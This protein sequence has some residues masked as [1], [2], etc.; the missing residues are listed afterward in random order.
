MRHTPGPLKK[1]GRLHE[2][3]HLKSTEGH[4]VTVHIPRNKRDQTGQTGTD[5]QFELE[6]NAEHIIACWNACEGIDPETV[7][8]QQATIDR[9]EAEKADL[10]DALEK[11]ETMVD[12]SNGALGGGINPLCLICGSNVYNGEEGIVHRDDCALPLMRAEIAKARP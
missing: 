4:L 9:L 7:P 2:M 11:T 10:L 3:I 1:G 8:E 5:N 6:A 12:E